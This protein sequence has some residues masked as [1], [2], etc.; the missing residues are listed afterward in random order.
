MLY[1]HSGIQKRLK[2]S[3]GGKENKKRMMCMQNLTWKRRNLKACIQEL[4]LEKDKVM[5]LTH[6]GRAG[7]LSSCFHNPAAPESSACT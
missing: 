4:K 5:M 2:V 7:R 3:V 6:S 1:K